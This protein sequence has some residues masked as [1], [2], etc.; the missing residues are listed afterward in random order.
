M[1]LIYAQA[2]RSIDVYT[3]DHRGTGR[4]D[5]LDC[6]AAQ[7][8][9]DGGDAGAG[10]SLDEIPGCI[11]DALFEID[12]HTE[13]FSVTSAARDVEYLIDTFHDKGKQV[14]LY[15]AS[16]GTYLVE[17]V[18]HFQPAQIRGYILDGT[19]SEAGPDPSSRL[20]FS[21]WNDNIA[22]PS[23]RF[24]ELCAGHPQCPLKLPRCD[25]SAGKSGGYDDV[26]DAVVSIYRSIDEDANDCGMG[27]AALVDS[28]SPPS[29]ALRSFMGLL[30]RD[31]AFRGLVPSIITRVERCTL[32]DF[33]EL[34]LVMP[35]LLEYI[36]EQYS[37]SMIPLHQPKTIDAAIAQ[38]STYL[39]PTTRSEPTTA[40]TSTLPIFGDNGDGQ[41]SQ[42]ILLYLLITMSELWAIPSPNED[43]LAQGYTDGALTQEPTNLIYYCLLH[44]PMRGPAEEQDP[45]C[46][47]IFDE[48]QE[49]GYEDAAEKTPAFK[50]SLDEF[51]NMTASIPANTSVLVV[52]GGL[53][54]QTPSEFGEYQYD[55]MELED[56]TSQKMLVH[57]D[58][59]VHVTGIL[60]TSLDDESN[61]GPQIVT[62][63]VLAGGDTSRVD[64]SCI[65]QLPPL[66]LTDDL[67]AMVVEGLIADSSTEDVGMYDEASDSWTN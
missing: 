65:D 59:G 41:S 25:E 19:V 21:H 30:V 55:H 35:A 48:L 44:A 32:Q 12:N 47:A 38:L 64:T 60:P 24:F 45:A 50:Y 18:M 8:F 54:F 2:N 27:L 11:S 63:F 7:A 43:E 36:Q 58:F 46:D 28:E 4:S 3:F 22:A 51:A 49:F 56:A 61:C 66:E 33:A 5:H 39:Q 57:F 31:S 37:A 52:N 20:F 34:S 14:F 67:F 10:L 9:A 29:L 15:G 26:L 13:A 62:D 17:R 40:R 23:R 6:V 1:L 16:Y 42:D 53:D